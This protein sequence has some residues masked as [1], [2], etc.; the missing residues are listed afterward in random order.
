VTAKM[1][2]WGKGEG[3]IIEQTNASRQEPW[4]QGL[5]YMTTQHPPPDFFGCADALGPAPSRANL[6]TIWSGFSPCAKLLSRLGGG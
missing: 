4:N 6:L 3:K 1:Q 5:I 2:K